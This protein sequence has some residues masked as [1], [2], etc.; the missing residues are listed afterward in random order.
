MGIGMG[1]AVGFFQ[2]LWNNYQTPYHHEPEEYEKGQKVR[3]RLSEDVSFLN[4]ASI[5]H[6]L[7]DVPDGGNLVI[8]ARKTRSIHHD[9]LEI[10]EDFREN[11]KIRDIHLELLGM[12]CEEHLEADPAK[13]TDPLILS[14]NLDNEQEKL[15]SP[16][17]K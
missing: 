13:S 3:V 16:L 6:M 14:S 17:L 11:A 10:I 2:I 15:A 9:V 7:S 12:C 1:L 5:L 8:D 4:K